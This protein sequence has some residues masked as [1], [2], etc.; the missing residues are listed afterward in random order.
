MG[1]E[2]HGLAT[3]D[4]SRLGIG[5]VPEGRRTEHIPGFRFTAPGCGLDS[6]R[7]EFNGGL[8]FDIAAGNLD[9]SGNR[10]NGSTITFGPEGG[11]F[12]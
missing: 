2:I 12:E 4:I 5:W 6:N 9:E 11:A 3:H 10:A 7:S 1:K 8:E